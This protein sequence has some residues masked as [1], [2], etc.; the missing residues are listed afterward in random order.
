MLYKCIHIAETV[1]VKLHV[2][3]VWCIF[4]ENT[5]LKVYIQSAS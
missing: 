3:H 4:L 1:I 5:K 2:L